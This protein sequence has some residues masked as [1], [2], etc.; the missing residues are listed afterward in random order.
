MVSFS[1][2]QATVFGDI[3]VSIRSGIHAISKP[4]FLVTSWFPLGVAF[5]APYHVTDTG[6][7]YLNN[8]RDKA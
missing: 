6:R 7:L 3:M 5:M 1:Y 8:T 4:P 2:L